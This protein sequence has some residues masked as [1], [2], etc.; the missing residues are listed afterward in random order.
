MKF[1]TS[2]WGLGILAMLLNLGISGAL[3]Y[4]SLDHFTPAPQ[5]VVVAE[6][7][8]PPQ[9]PNVAIP[10]YLWNFKVD[11]IE[12]L[13][14]SLAKQRKAL[15]QREADIVKLGAQQIAERGELEKLRAD[16]QISRDQLTNALVEV[17]DVEAKNLRVLAQT[18]S[19]MSPQAVVAIFSEMD[20]GMVVKMISLMKNDK[21]A[22]VFQEMA[23]TAGKDGSMAKR[24]ARISEKLRLVKSPTPQKP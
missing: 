24:A 19:G 7:A 2:I 1:L 9:P 6:G 5:E 3:I 12:G 8:K 22:A 14:D 13:V 4:K 23:R 10:P 20:E 15:E 11:E 21:A 16:L 17:R 18:Y